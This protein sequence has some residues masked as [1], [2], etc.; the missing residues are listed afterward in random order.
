M[1]N[2]SLRNPQFKSV[3]LGVTENSASCRVKVDGTTRYT[4]IKNRP[5]TGGFV[6][7]VIT[8]NFDISELARDYLEIEYQSNYTPQKVEIES[9]IN[10]YTLQDGQGTIVQTLATIEDVG[11]EAYGTFFENVNPIVPFR[12]LPT[13]LIPAQNPSPLFTPTFE[14]LVPENE[15]G[16]VPYINASGVSSLNYTNTATSI[17][18]ADG[19]TLNIKR[20]SC[21]KYGDGIKII[22]IN[23]YGAQQ[24]LW[25][26]LKNSKQIARTNEGYKS[27][28]ISY[29]SNSGATYNQKQAA[30]KLFNTQAKQ[31]HSLSSGYYPEASNQLFEELLLSE[32]VWLQLFFGGKTEI[33]PVNVK[34]SAIAF[35]TQLNDRLIQYTMEF[36]E[37]FDYINNIR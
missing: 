30:N 2:I 36:E 27:N 14:I 1:A 28:I 29:P 15:S 18:S 8:L 4:L 37:A 7:S 20:A 31:S 26:F 19:V 21:S 34:D 32:Y 16:R 11:F 6:A 35:K 25:F 3:T 33:I 24:D 13:Y 22:Y 12:S 17:V 23:K 10:T 5:N 9:D